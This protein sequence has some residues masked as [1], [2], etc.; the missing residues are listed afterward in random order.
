MANICHV[1]GKWPKSGHNRSHSMR[2]TKRVFKPNIFHKKITIWEW[3]D[4]KVK[5][6]SKCYKT[7]SKRW[8]M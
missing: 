7:L 8:E 4:V 5:I 3:L 2:A 1:C 6:C